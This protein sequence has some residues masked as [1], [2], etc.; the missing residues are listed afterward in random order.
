MI[1]IYCGPDFCLE[2]LDA[3]TIEIFVIISH[4]KQSSKVVPTGLYVKFFLTCI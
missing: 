1:K 2:L 4:Y 3:N